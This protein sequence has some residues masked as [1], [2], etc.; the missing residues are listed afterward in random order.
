MIRFVQG[1]LFDAKV[2]ALVNTVNTVGV[3]GKGI[4]LMFKEAAPANFPAYEEACKRKE[5][6]IGRMFVTETRA[7]EG[8]RWI[9]NFPTKKHW[10]QPSKME[11]IAEG[12]QDLRH[13]VQEQ[14]I[15]SIALPPLGAGNGQLDWPKVRVEIQRALSDLEGVDIV[16]YE[17]TEK[18]QNV[19]KRT[20]VDRTH[21]G[22]SAYRGDDS[23][24]LGARN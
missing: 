20:G 1:N 4:A 9:I 3:M 13:F 24:L 22:T 21:A 8:P 6:R 10:R 15:R 17:P 16:V 2:E 12:L 5:V 18:Y 14:S 7:F 23:A 19:A 11:W